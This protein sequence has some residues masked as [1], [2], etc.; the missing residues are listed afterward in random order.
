MPIRYK[1]VQKHY[2]SSVTVSELPK[3]C[4][5]YEKGS[6]VKAVEGTLGIFVFV[7]EE[8]AYNFFGYTSAYD[9][10]SHSIYQ[11]I[12][13]ET[14]GEETHPSSIVANTDKEAALDNF[15]GKPSNSDVKAICLSSPLG[16]ICCK[17]V[18]VLE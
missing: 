2:R 10:P 6:V 7:S 1:V 13:V 17:E 5:V 11:V 14:I 4:R 3:Y 12:K 18:L 16:T 15:Y 9:T 8:R